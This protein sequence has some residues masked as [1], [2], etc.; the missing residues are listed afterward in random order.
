VV[1]VCACTGIN[2]K[3]EPMGITASPA[4]MAGNDTP[5]P[6]INRVEKTG[7]AFPAAT[8]CVVLIHANECSRGNAGRQWLR[9]I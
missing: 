5:E 3:D 7:T 6:G 2:R 1:L 9:V 4:Q 8:P